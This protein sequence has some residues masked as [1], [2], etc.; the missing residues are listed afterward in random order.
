VLMALYAAARAPHRRA[1]DH[2]ERR[3]LADASGAKGAAQRARLPLS[4]KGKAT[5]I[6]E[7]TSGGSKIGAG[8][9]RSDEIPCG[10]VT[11]G[12]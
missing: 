1:N 2:V 11:D 9:R 4:A 8:D 10:F 7:S 6:G 5:P 12:S 3:L